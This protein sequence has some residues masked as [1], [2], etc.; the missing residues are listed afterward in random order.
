MNGRASEILA[1]RK[2]KI[3]V[4]VCMVDSVHV[5]KWIAQFNPEHVSFILFASGPNRRIHP[6]IKSQLINSAEQSRNIQIYPFRGMLSVPLW[7]TDKL[8]GDR[9]RG[10][11]LRRLIR[12]IR[13]D[14]IHA[15]EFQHSGYVAARALKGSKI[16]TP[17][18][19]TN[20]GSDIFWFQRFT[21]HRQKIRDV[22][23]RADFYSA[24]CA[25]DLSLATELGYQKKFLPLIPNAGGLSPFESGMEIQ[26]T[27]ERRIISIKGYQGWVGRARIVLQALEQASPALREFDIVMFSSNSSSARFARRVSRRTGLN[28]KVYGK[29]ALT[30]PQVL[31]IL[32]KSR[33][34]VGASLSDGISTTFLEA[35]SAGAF[36]IQ[37]DTACASEWVEDGV[38]ALLI[39]DLD[40]S[41]I[42]SLIIKA[43][44][45]DELVDQAQRINLEKVKSE[46]NI[47][48]IRELAQKFYA[49][50]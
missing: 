8:L 7:A 16:S 4:L 33:V 22:L 45:D 44:A 15:L 43:C 32:A 17:F 26:P 41:G 29:G 27:S 18:I 6:Q 49:L 13:P 42:A 28:L 40:P 47:D 12:K 5:A 1:D 48:K 25:R 34:Y 50:T 38:S 10:L 2:P 30:N 31:D 23:D 39:K 14:F 19:A 20:Y 35:L 21:K 24:E 9:L 37:T 46:A 3:V 11:L 36:P